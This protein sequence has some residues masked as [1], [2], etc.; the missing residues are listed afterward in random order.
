LLSIPDELIQA[1]ENDIYVAKERL[2]QPENQVYKTNNFFSPSGGKENG[3]TGTRQNIEEP[4]NDGP[5]QSQL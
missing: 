3:E 1:I 4:V 5:S 2:D